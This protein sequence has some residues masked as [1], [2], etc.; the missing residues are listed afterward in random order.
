MLNTHHKTG[1]KY[2]CSFTAL[3]VIYCDKFLLRFLIYCCHNII[4]IIFKKNKTVHS[5]GIILTIFSQFV[6]E[7]EQIH[8]YCVEFGHKNHT[9]RGW[10]P[11]EAH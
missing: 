6:R 4:L 5:V 7:H 10:C 2:G 9:L 11:E 3:F 1:R 8:K